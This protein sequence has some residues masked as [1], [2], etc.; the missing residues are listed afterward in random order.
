MS[1]TCERVGVVFA[2]PPIT[3]GDVLRAALPLETRG[4]PRHHWKILNALKRCRTLQ[5]GGHLYCCENCG[6][7]H[8][9]P[10]S[11]GN[12]HCPNCQSHQAMEWLKRQEQLLLPVPYFHII[13]TL[14]HALNPLIQQNQK[15]LYTLLFNAASQ[16]LLEFGRNNLGAKLG[17]T[18]VLHTWSQTLLDHYHVHCIVT[19][20][21]MNL[22]GNG[23]T[24]TG[25]RYL[26]PVK[27][28]SKVFQGKFRGGLNQLFVQKKLTFQG[29]L[30]H[31][32]TPRSFGSLLAQIAQ[33]NWNVYARRPFAGPEQVL[34]YLSRYTHRVALGNRRLVKF[35]PTAGKLT[36]SYK[37]RRGE[38]V[39][40]EKTMELDLGEFV[41]RFCLHLLPHRFVKL[42]HYG[43]LS[44]R[45]RQ[46]RLAKIKALLCPKEQNP[47]GEEEPGEG[48]ANESCS[49]RL[50]CP[51]CGKRALVLIETIGGP[52]RGP[53]QSLAAVYLSPQVKGA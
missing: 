48:S 28:L 41:R 39:P 14:D 19:G 25:N 30:K 40:L 18:V 36:F 15:A 3:L 13:F 49:P 52:A 37:V 32:A 50:L 26:F 33:K 51:K 22:K 21:G 16:T 29:Q 17:V 27:A 43:L 45:G 20:G 10:R 1:A 4:H 6:E 47:T 46:E 5:L 11:C 7:K 12:R 44:N 53:P 9:V 23:W 2:P 42:R 24:G 8:F 31:L 38:A 35:E 34:K